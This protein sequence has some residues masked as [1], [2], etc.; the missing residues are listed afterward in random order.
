MGIAGPNNDS[1][2]CGNEADNGLPSIDE[3]LGLILHW[4]IST[5]GDRND[6][7]ALQDLNKPALETSESCISPKQPRLDNGVGDS[8][9][10][11]GMC[12][13]SPPL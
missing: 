8:Q 2:N 3:I 9:G 12:D 10:I 5:G 13:G 7:A 11:R 6:K 1:T 4:G